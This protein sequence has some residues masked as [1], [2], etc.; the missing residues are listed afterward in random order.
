MCK[1]F[2]FIYSIGV[3]E[4]PRAVNPALLLQKSSQRAVLQ[5]HDTQV[6]ILSPRNDQS[7]V[8]VSG[9]IRKVHDSLGFIKLGLQVAQPYFFNLKTVSWGLLGPQ[10]TWTD[11]FAGNY[12]TLPYP[13]CKVSGVNL[14]TRGA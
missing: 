5:V 1:F 8:A 11:L 4:T 12:Y 2:F 3:L 9:E 7:C 14:D 13:Y 10:A 6:A